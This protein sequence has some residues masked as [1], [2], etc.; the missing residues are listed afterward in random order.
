MG[1]RTRNCLLALL[2]IGL[3]AGGIWYLSE[4]W[5]SVFPAFSLD[6]QVVD[7]DGRPVRDVSLT[8][9]SSGYR[10]LIPLPFSGTYTKV[11]VSCSTDG[12][13]RFRVGSPIDGLQLVSLDKAGY[14]GEL[15]DER[16]SGGWR[17]SRL[18]IP[19][20]TIVAYDV[21]QLPT[22]TVTR[23]R[24]WDLPRDGVLYIDL[25]TG[26]EV[27]SS[28][29]ADLELRWEVS[30]RPLRKY[31]SNVAI[32]VRA[33]GGGVRL[34]TADAPYAP[35]GDYI[36]GVRWDWSTSS[37]RN[38]EP[39]WL[40]MFVESRNGR[41][42]A[43]VDLTLEEPS[44]PSEVPPK[45][46]RIAATYRLNKVGG[47]YLGVRSGEP[48]VWG[49]YASPWN[50]LTNGPW[51][52]HGIALDPIVGPA[53]AASTLPSS[54]TSVQAAL[55]LAR[56]AAT[57]ADTLMKLIPQATSARDPNLVRAL[58]ENPSLPSDA[59]KNLAVQPDWRVRE[60][61]AAHPKMEE[62]TMWLL[63]A[64]VQPR[65]RAAVGKRRDCPVD[66]L[67]LLSTDTAAVVREAVAGNRSAPLDSLRVLGTDDAHG[68]RRECVLNLALPESEVEQVLARFPDISY[69][70]TL[71]AWRGRARTNRD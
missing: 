53:A 24:T 11:K 56:S 70:A 9:E 43:R 3:I 27:T 44:S 41:H 6:G 10:P 36:E 65:V 40:G 58:A 51:W 55:A 23:Y 16:I 37:A 39:V 2:A 60:W 57:S 1:K 25:A 12:R 68:V 28:D 18:G 46:C 26:N 52:A 17:F 63:A 61:V 19:P 50:V 69:R 38:R 47:R 54:P 45:A 5:R 20:A 33:P 8:F 15:A 22:D 34:S 13:G 66:M 49:K 64:D 29:E 62:S 32:E 4:N 59:I 14:V 35:K 7:Q 30:L 71:R 31:H 21:R 67:R 42:T 48:P